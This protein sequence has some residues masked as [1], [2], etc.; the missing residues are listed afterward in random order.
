M[1]TTKRFFRNFKD[2]LTTKIKLTLNFTVI[3]AQGTTKAYLQNAL[4]TVGTKQWVTCYKTATNYRHRMEV[5]S[6]ISNQDMR[7]VNKRDPV[8]KHIRH[9][10]QFANSIDFEEL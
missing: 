7:P 1:L 6:N 2:S 5:I 9:F 4:A 3:I 10:K 8:N